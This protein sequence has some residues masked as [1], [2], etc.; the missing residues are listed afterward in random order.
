MTTPILSTTPI[1]TSTVIIPA[2]TPLNPSVTTSQLAG[3]TFVC[4]ATTAPFTLKFDSGTEFQCIE[5]AGIPVASGFKAIEFINPTANAITV[6]FLVG[7]LGVFYVGSNSIRE[8]SSFPKATFDAAMLANATQPI[9]GNYGGYQR[10][11][12]FLRNL[13]I[14]NNPLSVLD[15]NGNAI[16]VVLGG[17]SFTSNTDATIT[18]KAASGP[19]SRVVVGEFYYYGST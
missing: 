16:Y 19:L 7:Q 1:Q 17:E 15:A 5:G 14:N 6:S 10:K 12:L 11:Q 4:V 18:L 2:G 9:P 3:F 8:R 13:D